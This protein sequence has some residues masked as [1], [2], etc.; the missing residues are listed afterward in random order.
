MCEFL[1][2]PQ[3]TLTASQAVDVALQ[4]PNGV[5]HSTHVQP[6]R[7]PGNT[8]NVA[9]NND[10]PPGMHAELPPQFSN[11]DAASRDQTELA[12]SVEYRCSRLQRAYA[13]RCIKRF[14]NGRGKDWIFHPP[15]PGLTADVPIQSYI[16]QSVKLW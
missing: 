1:A 7:A 14:G 6:G 12:D 16:V 15:T 2:P 13:V 11:V 5:H 3:S 10:G 4:N 9:T 8:T